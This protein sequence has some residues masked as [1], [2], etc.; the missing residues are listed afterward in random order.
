VAASSAS[1]FGAGVTSGAIAIGGEPSNG[2]VYDGIGVVFFFEGFGTAA[3]DDE[4]GFGAVPETGALFA[5]GV[6]SG[7]PFGAIFLGFGVGLTSA[8][9][10]ATSASDGD[11]EG[12]REW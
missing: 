4:D 9:L 12:A 8:P 2:S 10:A 7:A 6:V 3:R 1:F 5:A 11:G